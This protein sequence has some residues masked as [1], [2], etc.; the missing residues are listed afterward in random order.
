MNE[1]IWGEVTVKGINGLNQDIECEVLIIGGGIAGYLCACKLQNDFNVVLLEKDTLFSKTTHKTTAFI[2]PYQGAIYDSL[3]KKYGADV[4]R[5]YYESQLY[6]INEYKNI[7]NTLNI[8]C[9]FKEASGYLYTVKD[10]SMWRYELKAYKTLNIEY[11]DVEIN[12]EVIKKHAVK[13]IKFKNNPYQFNPIKFL[14]NL[15]RKFEV[16]E[17]TKV[18]KIDKSKNIAHVDNGHKI[19]AKHIVIAT[20]FPIFDFPGFYFA[21]AF[22]SVSYVGIIKSETPLSGQWTGTNDS[23]YYYRNM[24]DNKIIFGGLDHKTG[25]GKPRDHYGVLIGKTSRKMKW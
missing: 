18:V 24:D 11:E 2:T 6:A 8:E 22:R 21:K 5:G 15:D 4:A 19:R 14:N 23:D 25:K 13:A 1:K 12:D 17:H 16:Y 10:D 7:I 3:M 20:N 9:D